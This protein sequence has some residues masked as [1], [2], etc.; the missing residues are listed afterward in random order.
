MRFIPILNNNQRNA[1]D[2]IEGCVMV[3]AGPGT[4]KTQ[5]L[6]ARVA[7][8][9]E[10]TDAN[11]ENILCLTFTEAAT[12]ALRKRLNEFIGSQSYK[13]SVTTYHGFCNTVIQENKDYFGIEDLDPIDDLETMEVMKEIV[14]ELPND[15]LIKRFVGDVYYDTQNIT[16][17]IW[18]D[19][20]KIIYLQRR[21][22]CW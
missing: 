14:D 1:V 17:V 9:L 7:R 5:V 13:V 10:I 18:A 19:E 11:P 12:I 4:G 3:V 6:G 22:K 15:S 21:F 16:Q 8:I 20:K 2:A